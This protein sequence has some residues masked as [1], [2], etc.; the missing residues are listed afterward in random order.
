MHGGV[1]VIVCP[2]ESGR[3]DVE[4]CFE[5]CVALVVALWLQS[6]L[7]GRCLG[8]VGVVDLVFVFVCLFSCRSVRPLSVSPTAH[9]TARHQ[10]HTDGYCPNS[11]THN[12][13]TT[14]GVCDQVP[15]STQY[16]L[17]YLIGPLSAFGDMLRA[18]ACTCGTT[19][20]AVPAVPAFHAV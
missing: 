3:L 2:L 11:E 20:S 12:K 19:P 4:C 9:S 7:Q 17:N 13:A 14:P 1:L 18:G 10:A 6:T 8:C 16:V 5:W 15:V